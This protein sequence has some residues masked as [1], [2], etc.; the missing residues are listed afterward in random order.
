MLALSIFAWALFVVATV[1]LLRR[2]MRGSATGDR[3]EAALAAKGVDSESI[4]AMR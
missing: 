1:V 4:R 3:D 2:S